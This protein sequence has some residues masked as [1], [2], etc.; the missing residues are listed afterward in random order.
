MLPYPE[1][2]PV[3]L[4][5]GPLKVHWYGLAYLAGLGFAWWLAARRAQKP[6]SALNREQVDDLIFYSALGV[7]LGG[8]LGYILFYGLG[9][10]AEDPGW[11]LR[12][13]EGGMSFHGGML[14]VIFA[15]WLYARSLRVNF[16]DLLDFVAPLVPVGLGLGRLGNF[17]GQE[18]WG[19]ATSADFPL[20][21]VFPRDP[22]ALPR[23]PSQLYQAALEGLLLFLILYF[24]SRQP[25]PR[26]AVGGVFMLGYGCCRF[27]VEFVR[28]PDPHLTN[29]AFG[30]MTR[31]QVLCL[32]MIAFGLYLLFNAYGA[33]RNIFGER[34]A[35]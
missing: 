29:L 20:A 26:L 12:V 10:L 3:A 30:W 7:V 35:V 23:H 22:L 16:A 19:R 24:F 15:N 14:G 17:I 32:P 33:K 31:G 9:R 2:D 34:A 5:V 4:A 21:M 11:A 18:L 13:W 8:R 28:E 25:R 1:I 6:W 27:L